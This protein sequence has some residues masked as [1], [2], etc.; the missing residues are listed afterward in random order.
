M[1]M[2]KK[3]VVA[4]AMSGGVDSSVTAALLVEQGFSVVGIMLRLW[5]EK[6]DENSNRCCNPDSVAMARR[7]ASMLSIP[8]YVLD[9]RQ[10]FY[11]AVITPFINDYTHNRT[12]NP[13]INCN[14]FVRWQYLLNHTLSAGAEFL[15][16]GHYAQIVANPDQSHSL[17]KSVDASKDQSYVLYTLTQKHLNLAKFP[18]GGYTKSEVRQLAHTFKLPVAEKPDSQDLCFIGKN[19]DYRPFLIRRAPQVLDPGE[20]VDQQGIILGH[21]EGLA[22]YTIGQRK[23]LHVSSSTPLYV[24][25]KDASRNRLI[26]GPQD[27]IEIK[28]IT[29]ENVNWISNAPPAS[30]FKA[31]VK[32]RYKAQELLVDVHCLPGNTID[33]HFVKAVHDATPGQAAVLYNGE[34]CLGGGIISNISRGT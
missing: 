23:G 6:G 17:L 29:V 5:S 13:C 24:L 28:H 32:I 22:F 27:Y 4:V 7:V 33:I 31:K 14:H 15:A 8:F 11:D 21:H 16:T 1:I 18:L 2:I 12:P 20:I 9:A 34:V 3:P 25:E 10:I 19:G 30:S 26:I